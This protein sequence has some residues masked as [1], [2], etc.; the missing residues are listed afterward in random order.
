Q[1]SQGSQMASAFSRPNASPGFVHNSGISDKDQDLGP[2][3]LTPPGDVRGTIIL[4]NRAGDEPIPTNLRIH[5]VSLDHPTLNLNAS[6]ATIDSDGNVILPRVFAG[7]N[8]VRV[9]NLPRG[10]YLADI[11]QSGRSVLTGGLAAGLGAIE[12]ILSLDG[13]F[14]RGRT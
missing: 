14:V 13:G 7:E 2:L 6:K 5:P 10:A 4:K 1:D 8:M 3:L 12:I 11:T 9:E